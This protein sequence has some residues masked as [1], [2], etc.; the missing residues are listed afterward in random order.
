MEWTGRLCLILP[1]CMAGKHLGSVILSIVLGAMFWCMILPLLYGWQREGE[2]FFDGIVRVLG[3]W[4]A[5]VIYGAGY[6]FFLA[7]AAVFLKLCAQLASFYLVPEVPVLLLCL[8]PLAVGIYL[9]SS[10]IEVRG[11]LCEVIGPV[12]VT[13]MGLMIFLAAFGM[14]AYGQE[15]TLVHL[16]DNLARGGFEVF[17]CMGGMFAPLLGKYAAKGR[18][19]AG[20]AR[21]S[22]ENQYGKNVQQSRMNQYA[23]NVQQSGKNSRLRAVRSAG[24]CSVLL[25]GSLCAVAV[26]SYGRNGIA[27]VDF[28]AV[29]V[30]SNVKIPGNFLQRW[31]ILFLSVLLTE[32]SVTI[33]GSFWYMKE[34][35]ACLIEQKERYLKK[36]KSEDGISKNAV[37]G[38]EEKKSLLYGIWG[39]GIAAAYFLAVGFLDGFTAICYYRAY[40]MQVLVSLLLGMYLVLW[41]R[42][43]V[44]MPGSEKKHQAGFQIKTEGASAGKVHGK[45]KGAGRVLA[46]GLVFLGGSCFLHGCTAREPEERLF[47]M[48]LQISVQPAEAQAGGLAGSEE[49]QADGL[50][51]SYLL[52]VTYAWDEM[53]GPGMKS[54]GETEAEDILTTFTGATLS[55]I[56]QQ[57]TDFTERHVDYSHVKGILWDETLEQVP[58]LEAEVMEWLTEE[59]AFAS[60]LLVY[61]MKKSGLSMEAA[62]ENSSG[63]IGTYLEQLYRNN[64]K[65]RESSTT[66]GKIIAQYFA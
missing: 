18:N 60:G 17:A 31:D 6:L 1:V 13:L 45:W 53:T 52:A 33:G 42:S 32:I 46:L 43:R 15:E 12:A 22:E 40:P 65:Y 64:Q 58:A 4:A 19:G 2:S 54:S 47:P 38:Y 26:A 57:V 37:S 11:R 34:I 51:G 36:E 29:R 8:L 25:G 27:A 48:A 55:E 56:Q 30:M 62:A 41:I 3:K 10:G 59:P 63:Q 66:L 50:T 39:L 21:K 7:Q 16:E 24:L 5:V 14:E 20:N 23:R 9:S 49:V 28:P 61:P 44:K 35:A